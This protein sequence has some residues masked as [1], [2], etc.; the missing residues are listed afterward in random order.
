[1]SFLLTAVDILHNSVKKK[2][3]IIH[4]FF[5]EMNK[6]K[7]RHFVNGVFCKRLGVLEM[8]ALQTAEINL[9]SFN[10]ISN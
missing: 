7:K 3:F 4:T 9:N 5:N 6:T 2:H 10:L 1:M 8:D